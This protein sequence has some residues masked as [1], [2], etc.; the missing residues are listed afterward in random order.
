VGAVFFSS[1]GLFVPAFI[2]IVFL[3]SYEGYG[4]MNWKLWKNILLMI[5]SLIAMFA[6]A[7]VSIL[8]IIETYTGGHEA[9]TSV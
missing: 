9:K 5:F 8:D 1:L 7:F 4:T 6:G 2:E 3:S